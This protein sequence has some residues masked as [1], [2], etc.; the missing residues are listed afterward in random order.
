MVKRCLLSV[1]TVSGNFTWRQ[2]LQPF[3]LT[4][5]S[6]L[7]L[8]G[9][10]TTETSAKFVV[11]CTCRMV[12]VAMVWIL[13]Y[14]QHRMNQSEDDDTAKCTDVSRF[15]SRGWYFMNLFDS[16]LSPASSSRTSSR[17]VGLK[18]GLV[19]IKRK[20]ISTQL[21]RV[22]LEIKVDHIYLSSECICRFCT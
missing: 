1:K 22:C 6:S 12:N 4:T 8:F 20:D 18:V 9:L 15:Q 19:L 14:L 5:L 16:S 10:N 13:T 3:S 21:Y 11:G 17:T 7:N 2:T